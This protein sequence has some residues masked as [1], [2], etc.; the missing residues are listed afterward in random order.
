M[1]SA[2]LN[3]LTIIAGSALVATPIIIHLINRI[4][5]RRVK[6]A[7]MEF[8]L[9]AQ[10]KMRRKKILEQLLLLLLRCLLVFLA[11]VLFARFIG[12]ESGRGKE[13][14]PTTH[15]V[16]LD[17]T[18]SMADGWRR[19]DGT[20]TT[21]FEEA[22]RL[23]YERIMPAAAEA[24]TN[25]TLHVLRLSE[26]DDPY[27]AATK[28]VDGSP[29]ERS[30][31]EIREEARVHGG[32]ITRMEEELR[33][34]QVSTVRK[35]LVDGL[36]K[37][38][39]L[40][41]VRAAGDTAQVLHVVS[42]LRSADWAADGQK[43]GDLLKE[44]KENG[45]A[46]HLIDVS[47]PARK[48][49][50]KSPPFSDNVAIVELKPRNR[51]VSVNQQA[52]IEIRVKNFGSTDL[53]DVGVSFY[54]NGQGN[55]IPSVQIPTLPANQERTHTVAV[56]FTQT[57]GKDKPLERF[58][59]ITAALANAGQDGLAI[60]NARHT[61]VEVREA[62][63]V[64]VVDGRTVEGG[65]DL[66]Q[67][68]EGDSYYLRTLLLETKAQELGRIRVDSRE[69]KELD[70]LDLRPYS[71]VYLMNVPT[72]GEAAVKRLEKYVSEGGGVGV[73]LGPNVKSDDYNTRMF[74]GGQGF[75]PVQLANEPSKELTPEQ[76]LARQ[77]AFNKRVL[78]RESAHKQ[79]PALK[80]IYTND[81]GE[82]LKDDGVERFFYFTNIDVHW[83][84]ASRRALREDKL[85]Q[86]LYCMPNEASIAAFEEKTEN[87]VS[88]VKKRYGEA[89]FATA[90]KF[91]DPLLARVRETPKQTNPSA[92]LSVLARYLD[93]L[94]CD[95]INDGDESE[96]ILR[97]FWNDP[98]M[99][100]TRKQAMELRDE[101]KYGDPLYVVKQFGRGRVAVMTTDA[102]GT[103]ASKKTWTDW[104]S[105]KGGAGWVVIV[106][107]M[108]KY[109]SG[110]GDEANRSVG[111][112]F[113]AEFDFASYGP[114]VAVSF[115]SA[116]AAKPSADRK[117]TIDR[118]ELGKLTMDA[119]ANP[120]GSPPDAPKR[121]FQLSYSGAKVPG[122]YLFTLTRKQGAGDTKAPAGG[123][124]VTPD[125]LGDKDFVGVAFNVDALAEGDLR[126][127]NTDDL[128]AQTNKVPLH[129][130]EDLGWIDEFKQKP[131]DLS[132]GRWLYLLV[133]LVLI[134][135]QAWAVRI[136]YHTKPE[137]LELLAPSA[138][139]AYAHHAVPT[140]AAAEN[141]V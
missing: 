120:S 3:P 35:S 66:R 21:A 116:D 15:L 19:E 129:N 117:L 107:E 90:R 36:R 52:D 94:L 1:L 118:K 54:L 32:S 128:A 12:C 97:E 44:F 68:P 51:V 92:P 25:Q 70:S 135:E 140:P 22:K 60:D 105:G 89:K 122:A 65:V 91:L 23:V 104:S 106:G 67:K 38:K 86:E 124:A 43:I 108:H 79:H 72:L 57:G 138:A 130:T 139:A 40:L 6:W 81:R 64:L 132:S 4:R 98:E 76:Q 39:D 9:K 49:D 134:A 131:T 115:L 114:E 45:V 141:S 126:R 73:F 123:G 125:P 127:A 71:A 80:R 102:G 17:D 87:L 113:F 47:N 48:P 85:V 93:Q 33:P 31:E 83:P 7:A 29:K 119:P 77:L 88:E 11:G 137:D 99:A 63:Q 133:L 56:T 59:L 27:P 53:K 41:A 8:L 18:P 78:L 20:Q 121:P 109:L 84:V 16:I 37:A 42:D 13:T 5:F 100:E 30:V 103:H 34:K 82:L 10:K 62:V 96:P 74:R 101:A 110:G 46:V 24:T 50:R 75:F 58:N 61:V 14:R 112:R 2:F 55:V 69:A 28:V 95:Q 111:D 26:P 136:S